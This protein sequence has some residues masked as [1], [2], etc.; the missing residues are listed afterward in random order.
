[1]P[2]RREA[3]VSGVRLAF[4][5]GTLC[6]IQAGAVLLPGRALRLPAPLDR[7]RSGAWALVLPGVLL[8]FVIALSADPG[9]AD[10]LADLAAVTPLLALAAPVIAPRRASPAVAALA[11]AAVA[12]G[13]TVHHGVLG[14]TARAVAIACACSLLGTLVVAAAPARAVRAG[15]V[16]LVVLDVVLVIAGSVGTTSNALHAAPP[17]A[18]LP[19]FQDATIPPAIMGYGD[20]FGA[21]V[22]G[23]LLVTERRSRRL[24]ALAV[25]LAAWLFGCLLFVA[26]ELPATVPLLAG[27]A[28]ASYEKRSM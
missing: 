24:P 27:L 20:L 9:L 16:A 28:A 8:A 2:T 25:L 11:L 21:A 6:L 26:D 1:V 19:R 5:Y 3:S 10:R 23:A 13:I 14:G 15:L 22:L 18:G 12:I 7:L 17:P 4:A